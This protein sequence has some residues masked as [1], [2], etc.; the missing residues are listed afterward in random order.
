[1]SQVYGFAQ[2]SGGTASVE[3]RHGEGTV[4]KLLL[5]RSQRQIE[6]PPPARR[7]TA[8]PRQRG[9]LSVLVV[10]DDASVAA[11][12]VDMLEQ[13]GHHGRSVPTVA[14]AM[15]VLNEPGIDLVLTDV[16]LPGGASG[17][18]LAREVQQRHIDVPVIL[19]SGYGGSMTQRLSTMN[20]PL[21]RKPYQLGALCQAIEAALPTRCAVERAS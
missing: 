17:L 4:V 19:T 18:D 13:L 12:V 1:L 2:Q 7:H 10:E 8:T 6:S 20:L 14:A 3:S 21:L 9:N 11:M 16:L 15:A 5:P